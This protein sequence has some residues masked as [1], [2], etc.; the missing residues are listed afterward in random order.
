MHDQPRLI[1]TLAGQPLGRPI[2]AS[3][4][5]AVV[6]QILAAPAVAELEFHEPPEIDTL[7]IGAELRLTVSGQQAVLFAG[8]VT[9]VT[10]QYDARHGR[11]VRLRA[12]D[13]L[14][15][16]RTRRRV[17]AIENGSAASLA[18]ALAGELGLTCTVRHDA[19]ERALIIQAGESDLDLLVRLGASCGLYP[20]V[21]GSELRLVGL[22]GAGEARRLTLG[23]NLNA[24]EVTLS[25]ERAVGRAEASCWDPLTL[26]RYHEVAATAR[27]DAE[28]LR[29]VGLPAGDAATQWLV[30]PLAQSAAEARAMAQAAMDLAAASEAVA[31]G[32]AVGDTDLC[33]GAAIQLE[34]VADTAGGR[35]VLTE[36]THDFTADSGYLA[37]FSTAPPEPL[38]RGPAPS[39]LTGRVRDIADPDELGRCRVQ[40]DALG[41]VRSGWLQVMVPGA[42]GAKGVVAFPEPDDA[43]LVLLPDGDP[44]RGVVLGGLYGEQRLPRGVG[45]V[46]KRPFVIRTAGGQG[47]ELGSQDALARLS[48]KAGSMLELLPGRVRLA[49]ASDLVI[50]APGRTITLRA[51]AIKLERG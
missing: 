33:P 50:E 12:H 36:V 27:Q 29:D 35:F 43:V 32:T 5:V 22:E 39:F 10:H 4:A 44:A 19:P 37:R 30:G 42:G 34:G 3:L 8:V 15:R 2:G 24:V 23:L 47:L 17:R 16:T 21:S 51:D 48:T 28:E 13:P 26:R 49:A 45:A 11:V 40:L 31:V 14:H 7:R 46:R 1:V 9:A 6:R 20:T 38:T 41:D 18:R 25:G